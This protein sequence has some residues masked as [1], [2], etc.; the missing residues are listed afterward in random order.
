MEAIRLRFERLAH[1]E[2][3]EPTD[4]ARRRDRGCPASERAARLYGAANKAG[5]IAECL[6]FL[7]WSLGRL[8]RYSR[9]WRRFNSP[10]VRTGEITR[11]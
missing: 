1:S 8:T 5:V 3:S 7:D 2:V 6:S 4:D 10:Q 9:M 11:A